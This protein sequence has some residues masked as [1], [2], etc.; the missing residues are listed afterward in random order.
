M[1]LR[2]TMSPAKA[3]GSTVAS[4]HGLRS[5]VRSTGGGAVGMKEAFMRERV[6]KLEVGDPQGQ[7]KATPLHVRHRVG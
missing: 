4:A 5:T 3:R 6:A 2:S 1:F 7:R